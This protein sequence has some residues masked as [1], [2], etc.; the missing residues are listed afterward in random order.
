MQIP[1]LDLYIRCEVVEWRIGR[2]K[3]EP[4]RFF[5]ITY[6]PQDNVEIIKNTKIMHPQVK[7]VFKLTL[8]LNEKC[9]FWHG[10]SII[11]W[12]IHLKNWLHL[13]HINILWTV[14]RSSKMC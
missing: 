5:Q 3:R 7:Q 4:Y 12:F 6:I 14:D 11:N 10:K 8:L 2:P 13:F 1:P 9:L